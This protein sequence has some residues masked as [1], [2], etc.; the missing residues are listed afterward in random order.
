M[1]G[2]LLLLK[3]YIYLN[4]LADGPIGGTAIIHRIVLGVQAR[5]QISIGSILG[6]ERDVLFFTMSGV[7]LGWT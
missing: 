2:L 4:F 7:A 3:F 6:G 5:I 1:N